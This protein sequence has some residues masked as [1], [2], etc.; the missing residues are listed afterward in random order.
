MD[1][2]IVKDIKRR[3]REELDSL[4]TGGREDEGLQPL[5]VSQLEKF[6]RSH[7][8]EIDERLA[9]MYEAYD[10]DGD[11]HEISPP[12]G[13]ENDWYRE[14]LYETGDGKLTQIYKDAVD[15]KLFQA[16]Q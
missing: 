4:L 7:E 3:F 12:V 11:L 14:F 2:N 13:G 1:E 10:E 8:V 5:S 16:D 15:P 9:A 6:W